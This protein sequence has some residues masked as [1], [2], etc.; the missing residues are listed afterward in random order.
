MPRIASMN[1]PIVVPAAPHRVSTT[2]CFCEGA[3]LRRARLDRRY[4][5]R[6]QRVVSTDDARR[7]RGVAATRLR[8]KRAAKGR[9]LFRDGER[10]PEYGRIGAQ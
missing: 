6:P 1:V 9:R 4:A 5:S 2:A 3:Y 10:R 7:S 8:N